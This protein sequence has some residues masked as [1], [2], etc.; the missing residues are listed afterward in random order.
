MLI[1]VIKPSGSII[2]GD[3][4]KLFSKISFPASGPD[5][6]FLAQN[7]AKRVSLF[8]PHDRATEK[9]VPCDPYIEGDLIYTVRVAD[10][11]E[12]DLAA[13]LATK[14]AQMRSARD[15]ALKASDWTQ[16]A[17]APVDKEAW[18]TYREALRNLP[19]DENWPNVELPHDPNWVDPSETP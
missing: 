9:L 19:D 8:K 11:T 13:E 7:N 2:T 16:L 14:A 5:D 17:D 15:Q 10:K 3:Y 6:Q 18:A 1:G 4:K 12:E